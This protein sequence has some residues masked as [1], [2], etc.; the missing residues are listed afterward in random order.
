MPLYQPSEYGTFVTTEP[1]EYDQTPPEVP[2]WNAGGPHQHRPFDSSIGS[3]GPD[4]RV[5]TL[6]VRAFCNPHPPG[7]H[8]FPDHRSDG[9]PI[10]QEVNIEP[11]SNAEISE[12]QR[13]AK[14]QVEDVWNNKLWLCVRDGIFRVYGPPAF[15]VPP[16]LQCH[17]DLRWVSRV[18]DA[19]LHI[20][21]L[22]ATSMA[23]QETDLP[24]S[25]CII[26]G[27]NWGQDAWAFLG[28]YGSEVDMKMH[29][30][31][32]LRFQENFAHE[33][34]SRCLRPTAPRG[35]FTTQ[36]STPTAP[37]H[38]HCTQ[39][40]ERGIALTQRVFA[41]EFGHY[42]GL[43]HVCTRA[44]RAANSNAEYGEG[45]GQEA[46]Q[47]VMGMGD[48][49]TARVA[50]PWLQQLSEHRYFLQWGWVGTTERPSSTR[51]V[52]TVRTRPFG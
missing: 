44:G 25:N 30:L 5:F 6:H 38:A 22:K 7:H 10:S 3:L 27:A 35:T 9:S 37:R 18:Q 15:P 24:R 23:G 45:Q 49:V 41:H 21:L 12:F 42:L 8:T 43:N 31:Q 29:M 36:S 34:P 19:H 20:Q 52:R 17:I 1:V 28:G 26:G 33:F 39:C 50:A 32:A 4:G 14:Q 51:R 11:L 13:L 47:D 48:V 40:A 2:E 46:I 16:P